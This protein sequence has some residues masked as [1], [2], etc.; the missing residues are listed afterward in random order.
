MKVEEIYAFL[1][2][3]FPFNTA[4]EFD[5]VGILVGSGNTEVT[6]CVVALD[7]TPD[8]IEFAK[9]NGA[10]L[11][12]THHPVIFEP[13]KHICGGVVETLV[14][15]GIC[16]I[17]AHTN[18]DVA[19]L[20]VNYCLSKQ[21]ELKNIRPVVFSD[22]FSSFCGELENELSCEDFSKYLC[23]KLGLKPRYSKACGKIK[24]VAVCGGSGASYTLEAAKLANA[25]AFVTAD[26]KYN[27]FL[28]AYNAGIALFD[29]GHYHT[30]NTVIM[31]LANML[32][33]EF[34][35]IK[36]LPFNFTPLVG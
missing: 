26:V 22:G 11:I 27:Y 1:N 9:N 4:M 36:V 16:V 17:S 13:L 8:C 32:S 7:V 14:K 12:I 25:Q 6:A 33:A 30:E 15:N 28:E 31:P 20:G 10:N 19:P 34:K 24:T 35:N 3:N 21:L 5:N 2:A 23:A 18:L 29:C